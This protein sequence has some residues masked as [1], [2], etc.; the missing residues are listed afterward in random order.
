MGQLS[1]TLPAERGIVAQRLNDL[2]IE[3]R[4]AW[5]TGAS[6]GIGLALCEEFIRRGFAVIG[7]A[8]RQDKLQ[9]LAK[10]QPSLFVPHVGD[11]RD[12]ASLDQAVQL[13]LEKF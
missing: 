6:A 1:A 5:I 13:A 12:R 10:R 2:A 11:V 8:R 7:T 9:A 4:V 3:Q